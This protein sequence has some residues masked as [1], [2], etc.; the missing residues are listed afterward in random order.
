MRDE[1][2]PQAR[3]ARH[4]REHPRVSLPA[5]VEISA[6]E[7]RRVARIANVSLGGILV[8]CRD[9]FPNDTE[10]VVS[11]TLPDGHLLTCNGTVTHTRPH[12]RMA[13]RFHQLTIEDANALGR[14]V[15]Q[16]KKYVRRSGRITRRFALRLQWTDLDAQSQRAAAETIT[17]S[18]HGGLLICG[19]RMK[20]GQEFYLELLEGSRGAHARVVSRVLGVTGNLVELGFE[21][22]DV[23]N[24]W[25]LDFPE[26]LSW[27]TLREKI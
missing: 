8:L 23:Q 14:F 17:L 27:K 15:E 11:L 1:P 25:E 16:A 24:F 22:L 12:L 21:F 18:R 7:I 19:A 9:T 2:I 4:H 13:I 26:D 6:G 10:V 3:A 5:D 20:L